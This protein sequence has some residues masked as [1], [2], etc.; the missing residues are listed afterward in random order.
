MMDIWQA[1]LCDLETRVSSHNFESWF[2]NILF[3]HQDGQTA[4]LEVRDEFSKAWIEEN[5]LDLIEDA[6][7]QVAGVRYRAVLGVRGSFGASRQT[8]SLE[9]REEAPVAGREVRLGAA[10]AQLF[11]EPALPPLPAPPR[12]E[13]LRPPLIPPPQYTAPAPAQPAPA[14][15]I[16]PAEALQAAGINPRYTFDEFVVG[17]SNQFTH[18]ACVSI[19]NNPG[20][21]YNPLFIFGG[22]GLGKTHLL[23]AV[24]I[25]ILKQHPTWRVVNMSSE[26]FM[27]QLI[28]S[29]R[30]RDMNS[31][32]A[33]FR[34]EC[35]VLLIDDIQFIGSKDSTQ[36]E[37][38]H[39]FN[40]LYHS[41]KQIVITSDKPPKDMPGIE[42]R[43][44]SRFSWGLI[45]DIQP[46]DLET[47]IAILKKKSEADGIA[48]SNEVALLLAT[49]I[50]S[51]VRELEG[52]LVRLGAQASLMNV[53]ITAD[54]ARE[55]LKRINVESTRQINVD[56][57]IRVVA[58]RFEITSNDIRGDRRTRAIS[59]P[60]QIA[61]Y[62]TRQHTD[63]SLPEIGR[64][65]GGKDHTTVLAA[66][67]KIEKALPSD[68]ALANMIRSLELELDR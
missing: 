45:A 44:R 39:T 49:S 38:F 16:T 18:A 56:K 1:A 66:C 4:Y 47:R 20:K 26:E 59:E 3:H 23:Q 60:R 10:Q 33:H 41:G 51:N 61:M 50:R 24:G 42:E 22:V 13:N 62:L 30:Q 27:N 19:A 21:N 46:P 65:F 11:N 43:L 28:T 55:H 64:K 17:P 54:M 29:L 58:E 63:H 25:E 15:P 6:L 32:R 35:D 48:L 68:E 40:A 57:I 14:Q 31:F 67:R 8:R 36:E 52:T 53:P 12:P 7:R 34:D 5:Y 37:F 2:K 9:L